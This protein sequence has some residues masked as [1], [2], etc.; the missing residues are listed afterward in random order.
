M[1]MAFAT[2][3]EIDESAKRSPESEGSAAFTSGLGVIIVST[4]IKTVFGVEV[5]L[6]FF[7]KRASIGKVQVATR[8][9]CEAHAQEATRSL[10][11]HVPYHAPV[12]RIEPI[13]PDPANKEPSAINPLF[14]QSSSSGGK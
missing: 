10:P 3:R 14:K 12:T 7:V 6:L 1:A 11:L 2:K 13:V 9:P 5:A 4:Q 8:R